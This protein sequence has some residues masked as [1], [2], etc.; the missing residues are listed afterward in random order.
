GGAAQA[1]T[2]TYAGG[3]GFIGSSS[4]NSVTETVSAK[5]LT[6]SVTANNKPYDGNTT[7]TFSA[8]LNPAGI[9]GTDTVA[10]VTAGSTGAFA[11]KNAGTGKTVTVTGL[12]LNGAQ[13][14]NYVI[15]TPV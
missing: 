9:V 10:L 14:G 11:D 3:T 2:A 12:S 7:A 6:V 1:V 5:S 4:T 8:V 13:A 15:S